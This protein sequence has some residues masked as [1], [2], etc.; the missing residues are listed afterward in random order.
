MKESYSED[1]V[2]HT[3]PESCECAREGTFEALTGEPTGRAIEAAKS[4]YPS[5][6]RPSNGK[7]KATP[8]TPPRRDVHGSCAVE[9]PRHVATL[10][11]RKPGDLSVG[12]PQWRAVGPRVESQGNK[13]AMND[14]E[15]SDNSIVSK[16]PANKVGQRSPAAE[17]A[18]KRGLAKGNPSQ[19]TSHRT[20]SRKRLQSALERIRQTVRMPKLRVMHP[21]PEYRLN[22]TT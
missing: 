8:C 10:L 18:E 11:T 13:H 2:N 3:D 14:P 17:A 15:K 5:G 7:G 22:V 1:L 4:S 21:Y 9:E 16:K 19:Q 6:G 20:L 12:P